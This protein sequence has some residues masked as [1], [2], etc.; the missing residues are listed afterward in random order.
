MHS[1][2]H[3]VAFLFALVTVACG[4]PQIRYDHATAKSPKVHLVRL[5]IANVHLVIGE[6][7]IVF[8][9]GGAGSAEDIIEAMAHVG[10]GPKKVSLILL[11][12]G[13]ADHAGG[14]LELAARTGAPVAVGRGDLS[15]VTAGKNRKLQPMSVFARFLRLFLADR[16]P[17][18]TPAVVINDK[19]DLR[20]YGVA[21]QAVLFPGH[22]GGS[23]AILLPE[24][25]ALVGDLMLGGAFGGAVCAHS[26]GEHYYHEDRGQVRRN[27]DALLKR[28]TRVFHLGHG[29]PVYAKD[30]REA[31]DDGAFGPV[32]PL[33][34]GVTM[35][36]SLLAL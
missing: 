35:T 7:V 25:V 6:K 33:P 22:T 24:N 1:R 2:C 27:I 10:I 28:G 3:V 12:H 5:S 20:P 8:D 15:M 21:G 11:S 34:P 13:H 16:Y 14:S 29:G 36:Q 4:G 23:V 32:V 18:H 26:P 19:L 17:A 31:V 30:V 9:T